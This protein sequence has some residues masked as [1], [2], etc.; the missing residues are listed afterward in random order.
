MNLRGAAPDTPLQRSGLGQARRFG[1]LGDGCHVCMLLHLG[2][3]IVHRLAN[4]LLRRLQ[5]RWRRFHRDSVGVELGT[6]NPFA[7]GLAGHLQ[8][9]R[10]VEADA[11]LSGFSVGPSGSV[12]H[13]SIM[14]FA[15]A[16][17]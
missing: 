14:L 11:A 8:A 4:L 10:I 13:Q 3:F 15:H 6:L 16:I 2:G 7:T 9:L 17:G 1:G 5:L 12:E